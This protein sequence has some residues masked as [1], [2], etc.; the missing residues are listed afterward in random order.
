MVGGEVVA[1]VS[2]ISR[3]EFVKERIMKPLGMNS[4]AGVFQDLDDKSN[5]AYPHSSHN[6][7][8][9]LLERHLKSSWM[10]GAGG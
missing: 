3:N 10:S 7:E 4:S 2:G 8:L 5:V 6:G 9:K 1:R